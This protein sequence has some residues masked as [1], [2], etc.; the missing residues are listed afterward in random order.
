MDLISIDS[1]SNEQIERILDRGLRWFDY[2]RSDSR[3][4]DKRLHH[5][6]V[7]NLFYENSTRTAMSFATAAHRLGASPVFLPV[8]QSSIKKGETFEDTA[9]TLNA[10]R[11]DCIVVRHR[12]NG[13]PQRM[14]ELVNCPTINAGDGTNEHPTQALLDALTIRRA[15]L[16]PDSAYA[17]HSSSWLSP[18]KRTRSAASIASPR[19]TR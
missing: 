19:P 8:E 9:L 6:L 17:D 14:A 7:F 4:Q 16:M 5:K 10:M 13:A 11:P 15:G 3:G 1:L 18:P 12:E 2:N